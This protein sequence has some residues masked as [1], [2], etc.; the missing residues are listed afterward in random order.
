MASLASCSAVPPP[1]R[2]GGPRL[3]VAVHAVS[4]AMHARTSSA[5]AAASLMRASGSAPV[6]STSHSSGGCGR[7]VAPG[8]PR[9]AARTTWSACW[10]CR[11]AHGLPRA[12]S[13]AT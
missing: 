2:L 12:C 1:A 8:R 13:E 4:R 10:S 9:I 7:Q 6:S 5:S 11:R 3:T